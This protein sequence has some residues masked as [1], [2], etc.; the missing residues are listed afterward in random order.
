MY[1]SHGIHDQVLPVDRCSRRIVPAL[2]DRGHEIRYHE[3]DG[4]HE[5][6]APIAQEGFAFL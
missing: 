6:P 3:F 5:V 1:V 4:G 2:K